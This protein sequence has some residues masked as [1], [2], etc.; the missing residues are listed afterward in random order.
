MKNQYKSY[1]ETVDFLEDMVQSF[2]N[3]FKLESIGTTYEGREIMLMTISNDV[4]N[5]DNKPALLFTGTIHAREWIGS[6]L[7][8]GFIE[9]V[10]KM[11]EFDPKLENVLNRSA[12]YM[13]PILNPDGFEYSR[14]HFSFWRKNRRI[15]KDGSIGV[16]LN[17]NFSIG[18]KK[19]SDM[20]SNIYGGEEPFSEAETRAIKE[21]VDK[22][23]NITIALDYHSQG[24]VFFPAHKFKHEAEIDGTDLN[25]LCANMSREINRVTGRNY[26]IHR[27]KPP[28]NLISGSGRE[29]Y[30]SKGILA[31]VVE[32]GTKNIPDYMK[33]MTGF[34]NEHIPALLK[35]FEEVVNYSYLAPK[36]VDDFVSSS[37]SENSISLAWKYELRE[38][39]YFEI[40]RSTKDKDSMG[41]H[42]VVGVTKAQEFIDVELDS[43]TNY[44][45]TIRAV[46]MKT[47]YRS[48]F[49]PLVKIRT[50]LDRD[51]FYKIIFASKNSTGYV[52][53]Y[54][55]ENNRSHFGNNSLFVGVSESRG[56]S[57]G[58]ISFDLNSVP[59]N[60]KIKSASVYVYPINRVN[61]KI[62]KY[63]EWNLSLL[64]STSFN[65]V[66]DFDQIEN[67]TCIHTVGNAIE[68]KSL[69]QGI[70][71]SWKLSSFECNLLEKEIEKRNVVFR[72]DGPKSLPN[73][74]DSQIMQFDIGYGNFGGGIHYRPMLDIKY[75]LPSTKVTVLSE[76]VKTISQDTITDDYLGSGFDS[77]AEKV[78]GYIEFDL[79]NLPNPE[80]TVITKAF[81]KMNNLNSYKKSKDIRY[82][83][84]LVDLNCTNEYNEI[85]NREKIEYIGYE[86]SES[87]LTT[88]DSHYF[89]FDTLSK[90]TLESN[91]EENKTLQILIRATSPT[92]VAKD[93]IIK[94]D[95]KP[96]LVVEYIDKRK[97]PLEPVQDLKITIENSMIKLAWNNPKHEDFKGCYVV[98]NSFH[99]PRH[100]NDGVKL[101]GGADNYTYD[102]FGSLDRE[103][104]YSVFT[105]DDVP[106]FSTACVAKFTP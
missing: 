61:A 26:G 52:A 76:K 90:L 50:N 16:D 23:E 30:Y 12:I 14:K 54:T 87:D 1:Q 9:Y 93:R 48:P 79:S 95:E 34:V 43:S 42:N 64:D 28:A 6:E 103:K 97:V 41:P 89:L 85:K 104:Y 15:N 24:N 18:F 49:T 70:W 72:M 38:D 83:L 68:S 71:N 39:I 62:E 27:G 35:A 92:V 36:R 78:Y 99:P 67:A 32:V 4:V 33:S 80:T 37:V 101:Y 84:E 31:T 91:H 20:K 22:H 73:G 77:N 3:L 59:V 86:I 98:R 69:T 55:K 2:P 44:F 40:Y 46:N 82:Y 47:K 21:F 10:A 11:H 88:K 66:T 8:S 45:Y 51:E 29:Y 100:F 74:E 75:T 19:N 63:G 25:V 7:A 105:Y 53:E 56:I 96:K 65:D 13:V 106:N 60:A 102:N 58:V 81:I 5:S 57:N 94:W 17:R